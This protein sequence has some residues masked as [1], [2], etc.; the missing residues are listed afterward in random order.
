MV[1]RELFFGKADVD[2][3]TIKFRRRRGSDFYRAYCV[4]WYLALC[5]RLVKE[6][7]PSVERTF[8]VVV[9]PN[10]LP[11]DGT[12]YQFILRRYGVYPHPTWEVDGLPLNWVSHTA[13]F[14]DM[15]AERHKTNQLY[16]TVK[17]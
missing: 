9:S 15:L 17:V 11:I 10:Q 7:M 6:F 13:S 12:Q 4:G 1:L 3:V 5:S 16:V 14:L 8:R 2:S